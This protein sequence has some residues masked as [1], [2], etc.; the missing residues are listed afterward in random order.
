MMH[1]R[2]RLVVIKRL[3]IP[4]LAKYHLNLLLFINN[5]NFSRKMVTTFAKIA[6]VVL[7]N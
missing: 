2:D 3:A 7:N 1:L 6:E 4:F 5:P